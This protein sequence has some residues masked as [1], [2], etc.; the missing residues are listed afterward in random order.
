MTD[1]LRIVC[2]RCKTAHKVR[3]DLPPTVRMR[4]VTR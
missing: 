3:P 1:F 4:C 2:S